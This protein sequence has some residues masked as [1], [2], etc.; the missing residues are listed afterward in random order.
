MASASLEGLAAGEG[1]SARTLKRAR[2]EREC[3]TKRLGDGTWM[4][5]LPGAFDPPPTP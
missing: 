1:I 2:A 5:G 4:V 3:A